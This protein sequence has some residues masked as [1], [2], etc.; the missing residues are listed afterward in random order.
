VGRNRL[1]KWL[2]GCCLVLFPIRL[3]LADPPSSINQ[4]ALSAIFQYL[5]NTPPTARSSDITTVY[6]P[7]GIV[8][9]DGRGSSDADGDTLF[10]FWEIIAVPAG[11]TATLSDPASAT[12]SFL[13]NLAGDYTIRLTVSDGRDSSFTDITVTVAKWLPES[14]LGLP[15]ASGEPGRGVIPSEDSTVGQGLVAGAVN[16]LNGNMVETRTDLAIPAINEMGL[17]LSAVYNSQSTTIG[18]MGYGWTHTFEAR[19]DPAHEVSGTTYLRI[20]DSTGRVSYFL[21]T[22]AGSN[23]YAG[24]FGERSRVTVD[25]SGYHWQRLDGSSYLFALDDGRLLAIDDKNTNRLALAYDSQNRLESVTDSASG[26]MITFGYRPDGLLA[27][28]SGPVVSGILDGVWVSYDYNAVTQDLTKVS[29]PDGSGFTYSYADANDSHNLTKVT[30]F[31]GHSGA[32][33]IYDTLDRCTG[34]ANPRGTGITVV[35]GSDTQADVTDAYGIVRS[36]SN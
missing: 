4:G 13:A 22:A 30:N 29:Y 27:T 12:P 18:V 26:R 9:L 23:E 2:I 21:V 31:A 7:G 5:L 17:A 32:A 14:A 6:L 36:Y 28:V 15:N 33:Y 16:I 10:Y 20:V 11:S 19:L 35:Y 1:A 34:S 3:A 24:Q 8:L 25:A